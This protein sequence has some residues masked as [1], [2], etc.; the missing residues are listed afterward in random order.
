MWEGATARPAQIN[1]FHTSII[2]TAATMNT[3]TASVT[4]SASTIN[5]SGNVTGN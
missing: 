1:R 2:P 5:L 3:M 4:P